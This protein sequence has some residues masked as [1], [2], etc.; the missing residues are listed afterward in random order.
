MKYQVCTVISIVALVGCANKP[1]KCEQILEVK[2]QEQ[3]CTKLKFQIANNTN[4]QQVTEARRRFEEL[5]T[6]IRYY[7]NQYDTICKGDEQ[8][9]SGTTN[10]QQTD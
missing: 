4:P 6:D 9:I 10:K 8:P 3:T 1:L 5:C 2:K 7:R